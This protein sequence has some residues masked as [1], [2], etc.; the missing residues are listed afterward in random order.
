MVKYADLLIMIDVERSFS[1]S[2]M[3]VVRDY[4]KL[5]NTSFI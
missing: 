2:L 1:V 4:P 3:S 5:I